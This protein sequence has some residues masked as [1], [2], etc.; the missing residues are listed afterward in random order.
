MNRLI[1]FL[2]ILSLVMVAN[3]SFAHHSFAAEFSYEFFGERKGD[4]MEVLFVNPHA[5][6]FFSVKNEA[7]SEEIWSAQTFSPQTLLRR[8]WNKDTIKVGDRITIEGNLGLENSRR[9]WITSMTLEDG[10][11]I[12]PNGPDRNGYSG[13]END[14]KR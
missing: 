12:Q 9:L 5:R 4:V 2:T 3:K 14:E 10:T 1:P 11:V 7:G 13:A 6:I 8:G